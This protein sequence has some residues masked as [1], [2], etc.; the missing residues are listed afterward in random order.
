MGSC[1]HQVIVS[2]ARVNL[3]TEDTWKTNRQTKISSS[4]SPEE[5]CQRRSMVSHLQR[6]LGLTQVLHTSPLPQRS[7][8]ANQVMSVQERESREIPN[9]TN[10]PTLLNKSVMSNTLP[11]HSMPQNCTPDSFF[12]ALPYVLVDQ[13]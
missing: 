3:G 2:A 4:L 9:T 5:Q 13:N 10:K 12:S 7:S 1:P 6:T 11:Y 8:T